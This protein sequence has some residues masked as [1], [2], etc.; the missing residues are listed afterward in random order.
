MYSTIYKDKIV[1]TYLKFKKFKKLTEL[2]LVSAKS[3]PT[4]SVK[5]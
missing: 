3:L 1:K 4:V 2:S 5:L